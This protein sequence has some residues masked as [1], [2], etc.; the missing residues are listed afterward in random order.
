QLF[1]HQFINFL[2]PPT[3]YY[4]LY[5]SQR[6]LALAFIEIIPSSVASCIVY[7][8]FEMENS[9]FVAL[10]NIFLDKRTTPEFGKIA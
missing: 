7:M 6:F 5:L 1:K 10:P 3:G 4:T 9:S 2:I 8:L